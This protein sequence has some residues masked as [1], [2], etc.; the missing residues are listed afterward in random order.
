[1]VH[2]ANN[3]M[4][5]VI[6]KVSPAEYGVPEAS[7]LVFHPAKIFP[8]FVKLPVLPTTVTDVPET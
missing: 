4:G 1:M 3:M 5:E 7:L 2:T 6:A 8:V